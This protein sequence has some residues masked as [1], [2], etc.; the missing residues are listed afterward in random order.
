VLPLV[1]A[2]VYG[3]LNLRRT[4]SPQEAEV[5]ELEK[6][7]RASGADGGFPAPTFEEGALP[8][9]AAGN[10]WQ[11]RRKSF[12][13]NCDPT[14]WATSRRPQARYRKLLKRS[15]CHLQDHQEKT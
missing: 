4:Q 6:L 14:G 10:A 1:V 15:A 7:I 9:R 3:F 13:C 12:S 11:F 5:D 2:A 8:E